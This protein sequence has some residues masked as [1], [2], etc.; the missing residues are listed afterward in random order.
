[1]KLAKVIRAVLALLVCCIV[2]LLFDLNNRKAK[3]PDES[4]R[5]AIFKICSRMSLDET[6]RGVLNSLTE[7][8]YVQGKNCIIQRFN[9]EGD[10]GVANLIANNIVNG[11]FDYVVTISTP[12]LQI[13]ANAN[14][15][16]KVTN[17]FC[18]VTDPFVSGVGI[19]GRNPEQHP[20]H[21]VGIGTFQPVERAF[22]IARQMNPNLKKVGTVWCTSETCS[23]A[24]VRLARKKCRELG[25]ELLEMSVESSTQILESAT[26]LT[27]R[28]VEALWLG[29]DNVVETGID[30]LINAALKAKIPLFTNSAYNI[31][32][33]ALF[34]VGAEYIE[35]GKLAGSMTANLIEGKSTDEIRIENVVP[36]NLKVNPDALSNL[37]GTWNI[38]D[39][40]SNFIR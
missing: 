9:P 14:K 35:L 6:E 30:Q 5:I 24:C 29:G 25:I 26:A 19:T 13:M 16:G 34:G 18:A 7:R 37:K 33:N 23:E 39:F 8:G 38:D 21:L 1:M 22:E 20:S 10:I 36:E 32:G 11:R 12:A 15:K 28:G 27:S 3:T 31:Y 2:L 4:V 40:E 17:I